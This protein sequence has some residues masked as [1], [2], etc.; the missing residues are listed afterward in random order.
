MYFCRFKIIVFPHTMLEF[1]A[2]AL[3]FYNILDIYVLL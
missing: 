3:Q 2:P 1:W